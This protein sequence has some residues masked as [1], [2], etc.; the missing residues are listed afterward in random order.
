MEED[1][2]TEFKRQLTNEC[3]KTVVAFSNTVGGTLYIGMDDDGTPF[4]VND[5][6]STSLRLI[7]LISDTIRPDTRMITDVDHVIIDGK[8]LVKVEVCEGTSKPYYL[9]EKG[10]R[11]EGVY[12][13]MGPSSVQATEAQILKMVRENSVS[14]ESLISFNQD[15]TF[16]TAEHVFAEAGVEFGKN[17]MISLGLIS[18]G[19]YTNLAY[20]IS[21]QCTAGMKLAAYS[22]R[23]K[24]GFL[25]RA[26]VRGS[27]LIQVRDAMEFLNRYNPLRS[28]ISGIRR[29]DW[30]AY[31]DYALRE[32]LTNAVVHRDY[33]VNADTL[34]SVF[35][36]GISIAS[37]GG[38]TKGLG[39]D[40]IIQ[41]MSSPRNP[42]MAS[43]FYRLGFI[44]SYGT[45]IPRMMGDYRDALVKPSIQ[46]STNVFKVELPAIS[47][48]V[49]GQSD[50]D[51]IM[52]YARSNG[53]LSRS[54]AER[55]LG[56]SRSKAGSLLSSM[57]D[58]GLLERVGNGKQTRYRL[59][60]R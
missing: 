56:E 24:T 13:R 2:R 28:N 37:Y 9:R 40:D 46:L 60:N 5:V 15:L 45:G 14:F 16:S 57:V 49:N 35:G 26:E 7:Q 17:Q 33:S 39:V 27:I 47:P 55:I 18:G 22:D 19:S 11:P 23:N 12:V 25:D 20:L 51:A 44:E 48:S 54:D 52:D 1:I 29:M 58:G 31:P 30:R 3:M 8:D 43:L 50:V 4:G 6:D 38:L 32:A 53:S 36:D 10:L 59:Q 34:V 21:D 42:M 41:G